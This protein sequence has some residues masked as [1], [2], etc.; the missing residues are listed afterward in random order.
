M[1][2][3]RLDNVQDVYPLSPMQEGMLF[4]AIS[5]P[6]SGVFVNQICVDLAGEVD[7][8]AFR[9][10][11]AELVSRHDTLRTAFL[12]DGLDQPLQVVREHVELPWSEEDWRAVAT[13]A[14]TRQREAWLR[15]DRAR[16]F[17]LG[18]APLMRLAMIRSG[19]DTWR[20][21]W[22]LHHLVADG[23]SA[24]VLLD[25]LFSLYGATRQGTAAHLSPPPR[26]RDFI[27]WQGR[28]DQAR[29]E[30]R[31]RDRLA[32]F[33]APLRLDESGAGP[34]P[35]SAGHR[36]KTVTLDQATTTA[37]KAM[38]TEQRVTLNTAALGAWSLLLARRAGEGDVVFGVTTSGRPPDLPD[39]ER[40]VGLFINTLPLR[41]E[42]G[43]G[44]RLGE[45]LRG[46][47][48]TQLEQRDLEYSPLA[49][50]QRWS[51][52]P[53][54]QPLFE[55]I[56]VFEN[57]PP[58]TR[59]G[60][61]LEVRAIEFIEHSNYPLAVLVLP[62]DQL[63]VTLVYDTARFTDD[64]IERLG[65][66][67]RGL[68]T[69]FSAGG[70]RRLADFVLTTREQRE[71]LR[72]WGD[73]PALRPEVPN[74]PCMQDLIARVARERPHATAV[75]FEQQAITYG[76]LDRAAQ[77]VADQL[78][79][80]GVM[81]GRPV[82]L[83]VPRSIRM[84]VGML[85]IM[86]AGG[87]YVPLDPA[88]PPAHL[89]RLLEDDGIDIVLTEGRLRTDLPKT[90][91]V[92]AFDDPREMHAEAPAAHSVT[93]DHL[94]YVIHTS[95]S[96]GRPKGVM[97]TH[98]NLVFSTRA[99][100]QYYGDPVDRFLLLSS[101]AFDS[102]VVGIFWTLCSGGTL[103]LPAPRLEQDLDRLLA[104]AA[105]CRVSH[106]LCLPALYQLM[107]EDARRGELDP[108]RVAIV[109]GEACGPRVFDAHQRRRPTAALYNE[110]GPTEASVWC[111]AHRADAAD[112][113]RPMPIGR[114]IPGVK[115]LLLDHHGQRAA[116]GCAGELYV[117]GPG[118]ARGYLGRPKE[119][120]ERFI[121]SDFDG[122]RAYRTGDLASFRPDGSLLF[123][124]RAD[125]QLKVRGYRVETGAVEAALL[126]HPAVAEAAVAGRAAR[127]RTAMRLVGYVRPADGGSF[128]VG[129]LREDLKRDLPEFMVPAAIVELA[130]LPRRPNGK[131]DYRALPEPSIGGDGNA[132]VAPRNEAERI[133]TD[134]WSELLG[135][136]VSIHDDYFARG[137][138]SILSIQMISRARQAGV[139]VEPGQVAAFPTIAQLAAAVRVTGPSA[140]EQ[141]PVTG[142]VPLAPIQHWFFEADLAAPHHWNQSNLFEVP[143]NVDQAALTEALRSC[144]EHHD[145]LRARFVR[146]GQGWR[147]VVDSDPARDLL[148]VVEVG[149]EALDQERCIAAA[150]SAFDLATG[151]LL[152]AVLMRRGVGEPAQLLIAVHHLII[153]IV[154]WTILM[155]DLETAYHQ[156]SNGDPIAL[157]SRTTPYR[158]WIERLSP[159]GPLGGSRLLV[160]DSPG[161]GAADRSAGRRCGARID[162]RSTPRRAQWGAHAF[163]AARCQRRVS[164]AAR[165]FTGDR[166]GADRQRLDGGRCVAFGA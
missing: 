89:R 39:V 151:P 107:L 117:A 118:V 10:A 111:I 9:A 63:A 42:V 53:A 33:Q 132:P 166:I 149:P 109:A 133:L 55:N 144:V 52:V 127:G 65:T 98:R 100:L 147:Q 28:Q 66:Q 164:N 97:V 80:A 90:A 45:W 131:V 75:V 79:R 103:V 165:G 156:R 20:L 43:P 57:Y 29:A 91:L 50:V 11:W 129:R 96:T 32:E 110:Y 157:P 49:S 106:L 113:G 13:D 95:G 17:D 73:G 68:L 2:E 163:A 72:L 93:G 18:D 138:D 125:A 102:S 54:G 155:E 94:A 77:R 123:L 26:Y 21:H 99:R 51:D 19:A 135:G 6:G 108:L 92:L 134:I 142:D 101:F 148:R 35:D 126:A 119:T 1:P 161:G 122:E 31:W 116:A 70:E 85:G 162:R 56:F 30:E 14:Q 145:M 74:A 158:D 37:L 46:I 160:R 137:G 153:D 112:T 36:S 38:A 48:Q 140:S 141:G 86:K 146:Q 41:V 47:Q 120:A 16:G 76:A 67:F 12:W 78:Q 143:A 136:E 3:P 64:Q 5:A 83:Y 159:A 114:P 154:S 8:R 40:A 59:R 58:S 104:L 139:H 124:G 62:G 69:Q 115:I 24:Q 152:R 121:A 71:H 27:A 84:I 25:E 44:G 82:G 34:E 7:P 150:Q 87:A 128:D 130:S 81:P 23:W 60:G 88:Y 105:A 22:T 61:E 4:H 15:D